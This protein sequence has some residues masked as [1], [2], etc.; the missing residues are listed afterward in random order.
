MSSTGK[1]TLQ[2]FW[3]VMSTVLLAACGARGSPGALPS[4]NVS[5]LASSRTF[6]FTHGVQKFKV[7]QGVTE[8]TI[9]AFGA[10]G[11]G[12]KIGSYGPPGALGAAIT[13]TVSVTGGELLYVYVA[14]KGIKGGNNGGGG[15]FNGGGGAFAGAFG[16]GGSSD[17]RTAG[18]QLTDRII[19]AAGG[20][21]S[22]ESGFDSYYE[23]SHSG[24]SVDFAGP[25]GV[26]GARAGSA[27][28]GGQY[29]GAGGAGGSEKRG[30]RGGAGAPG[31]SYSFSYHSKCKAVHGRKG[32]LQSGG[33]GA[34]GSCGPAGGGGAGGYYGGGGGGG[35]GYDDYEV[36]GI[37]DFKSGGG[38]GGGGASSFVEPSATHVHRKAGGGPAGDGL[39]IIKW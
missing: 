24:S 32:A 16:G 6:H 15:G 2:I 34:D 1:R 37:I 19:V 28:G 31:H 17:V 10:Q 26:G 29:G 25:G 33:Q 4:L 13:A 35:G 22:G 5:P 11:G 8:L 18:D 12:T 36:T 21:G 3:I 20:G 38:G 23:D 39:V 14:G 7:P 30:G 9:T 27:G